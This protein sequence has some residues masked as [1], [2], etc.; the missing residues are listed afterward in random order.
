MHYESRVGNSK[1]RGVL[2]L[3][4]QNQEG[5]KLAI[6]LR[7]GQQVSWGKIFSW[8]LAIS[9]R[10]EMQTIINLVNLEKYQLVSLA[11]WCF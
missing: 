8:K 5:E 9:K 4:D 7:P 3:Q 6:Y 1:E 10:S 2:V 11:V